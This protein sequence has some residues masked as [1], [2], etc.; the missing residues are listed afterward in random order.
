MAL[1]DDILRSLTSQPALGAAALIGGS[2][3]DREPG[4]VLEARQALRN[5]FT[6][7]FSDL[8]IPAARTGTSFLERQGTSPADPFAPGGVYASY[9]PAFKRNEEDVLSGLQTQL[10]RAFPASAGV[11]LQGPVQEN[12]RRAT[13]QLAT[14]RNVLA[15]DLLREQQTRQ[16]Q[17][18]TSLQGLGTDVMGQQRQAAA[19]VLQFSRPDPTAQ[20]IANLG[21]ILLMDSV[22]NRRGTGATGIGTGVTGNS[23]IDALIRQLGLGG[24]GGGAAQPG[25]AGGGAAAPTATGGALSALGQIFAPAL[26]GALS[27]YGGNA[28]QGILQSLAP[29]GGV[30][31][32][33]LMG[34]AGPQGNAISALIAGLGNVGMPALG[35]GGGLIGAAGPQGN[36]LAQMAAE[37]GGAAPSATGAGAAGA[38]GTAAAG[39]AAFALSGLGGLLGGLG[40]G[41]AGY[42]LGQLGSRFLP[43]QATS[44][45]G[46]AAGGAAAG[47]VIGSIVPG[48]GTAIG[49]VIGGVAGLFGGF[50]GERSQQAAIK[51]ERLAADMA[52]QSNNTAQLGSFWTSAIGQA[53][54]DVDGFGSFAQQQLDIYQQGPTAF[55]YGGVSGTLDQGNAI[56]KV[57]A[58]QTLQAINTARAQQGKS[59]YATLDQVDGFRDAYINYLMANLKVE[60]GGGTR[61]V[62]NVQEFGGFVSDAGL[63]V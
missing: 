33:G 6:S 50:G 27:Q 54:G 39:D 56:A 48:L 11:T 38:A 52:S 31:G 12:L 46:G 53:G 45:L 3:M 25:A 2:A 1:I 5:Q 10:S 40:A 62:A 15:A 29:G 4:E 8:Q 61:P 26:Q 34:A 51:A 36:A 20:S 41:A 23:A 32:E 14:N 9:L 22:L 19:D 55:S 43:N 16:Q 28:I 13:E 24:G 30:F 59:I 21:S 57:G 49:A 18:A 37:F 35:Q 42:G 58:A 60:S 47:A 63:R 17:A 7:P 44:A